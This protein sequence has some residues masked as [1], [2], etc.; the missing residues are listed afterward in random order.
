MMAHRT[1]AIALILCLLTPWFAVAESSE[2]TVWDRVIVTLNDDQITETYDYL[3]TGA[4]I[5]QG[6]K[7]P[8]TRGLQVLLN[9][10]GTNLVVDGSVGE[11][12][13]EQLHKMIEAYALSPMDVVSQIEYEDLMV[14]ALIAKVPD[15]AEK[16]LGSAFEQQVQ[17]TR[18]VQFE[19]TG[20]YF[21]AFEQFS[22]L[23]DYKDSM[24]RATACAQPWPQDGALIRDSSYSD[25]D[26]QLTV[27]TSRD[28]NQ[29][30]YFKVFDGEILVCSL[31]I[32]GSS[33]ATVNLPKGTYICKAGVGS[34][35][36]G[37]K[38]AFGRNNDAAYQRLT[39]QDGA[40]KATFRENYTY[41]LYLGGA[42]ENNVNTTYEDAE[43]F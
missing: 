9:L 5:A 31:F 28:D 40:D 38:E 14:Q 24:T 23:G 17:Y 7:N 18:A 2:P 30:T 25:V 16:V 21:S 15:D 35:W 26:C 37:P 32:A 19:M 43:T 13:F 33:E 22:Y 34:T 3:K 8:K 36:Y 41:T 39:F 4:V 42:E 20:E 1:L 27:K 6:D 29:A 11:K 10:L 12:T